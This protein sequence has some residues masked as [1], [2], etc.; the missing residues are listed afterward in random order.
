MRC[1]PF[2]AALSDF[3]DGRSFRSPLE[4]ILAVSSPYF[5]NSINLLHPHHC[6]SYEIKLLNAEGSV[7]G[8][9]LA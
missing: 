5:E 3:R 7:V 1:T 6:K 9:F 4:D 2:Q 8:H